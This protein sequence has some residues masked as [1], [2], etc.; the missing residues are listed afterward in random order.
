MFEEISPDD[1]ENYHVYND[2][3]N[4]DS[5]NDNDGENDD[6]SDDE[7]DDMD[8]D[9]ENNDCGVKVDR[10]QE[11]DSHLKEIIEYHKQTEEQMHEVSSSGNHLLYSVI[12]Q[13]SLS[14]NISGKEQSTKID[15]HQE[16][17]TGDEVSKS[18]TILF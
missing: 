2:G 10:D 12:S 8:E 11:S 15:E 7:N 18:S 3:E 14:Q 17:K 5:C 9:K 6:E 1:L 13:Y 4:N 16:L